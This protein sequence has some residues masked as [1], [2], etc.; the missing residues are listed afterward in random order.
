MNIENKTFAGNL[1]RER[2]ATRLTQK[3][4][5]AALCISEKRYAKWE[6]GRGTPNFYYLTK[7]C[8]VLQIDDLYLFLSKVAVES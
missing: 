7:I 5:A 8:E 6:E 1:K 3:E 4:M 2:K